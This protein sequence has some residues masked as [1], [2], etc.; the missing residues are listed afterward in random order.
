MHTGFYLAF[1][2][3]LA[4]SAPSPLLRGALLCLPGSVCLS[5]WCT[6]S[7]QNSPQNTSFTLPYQ[8]LCSACAV[9]VDE[10]RHFI[11]L[12]G[13]CTAAYALMLRQYRHLN[14]ALSYANCCAAFTYY[15]NGIH[16]PLARHYANHSVALTGEMFALASVQKIG[17]DVR[18]DIWS[19]VATHTVDHPSSIWWDWKNTC[20][21]LSC[22]SHHRHTWK[23]IKTSM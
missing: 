21:F 15:E 22:M 3:S 18:T 7:V 11:F 14:S 5:I 1:L 17:I 6:R 12:N 10:Y 20:R 2:L 16:C 23:K 4:V 13:T 9:G 19:Q 8:F